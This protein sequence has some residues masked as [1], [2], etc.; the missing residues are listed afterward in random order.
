MRPLRFAVVMFALMELL[1]SS[2]AS[3]DEPTKVA[4]QP[5]V[6]VK[7][8]EL[9]A[10]F[11]GKESSPDEL[12]AMA[13]KLEKSY[14]GA[15]PEAVRMLIAIARGSQ[16]GPGEGWF[17]GSQSRYSWSWMA[18]KHEIEPT[19]SITEDKFKGPAKLFARLDRNKDG[20]VTADDL[21]WSDRHPVVQQFYMINRLF[22]KFDREGDGRVTRE[23]LLAFF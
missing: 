23:D 18:K 10:L 4:P 7:P 19:G 20:Q 14:E 21:D 9:E 17:G 5:R 16:M 12:K 22:R 6:T 8:A 11:K 1:M 13:D 2:R 3:A 15:P